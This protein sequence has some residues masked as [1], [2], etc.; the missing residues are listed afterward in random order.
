MKWKVTDEPVTKL[1]IA[2]ISA[3]Q[4]EETVASSLRQLERST[5]QLHRYTTNGPQT[6]A[7]P[8]TLHG[9]QISDGAARRF[10]RT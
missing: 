5:L 1:Q 4:R 3:L 10:M 8:Q 2:L 6:K 9:L 7:I